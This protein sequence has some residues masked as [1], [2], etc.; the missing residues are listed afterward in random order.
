MNLN[1]AT[2]SSNSFNFLSSLLTEN[3]S[4][5]D[6]GEILFIKM[7]HFTDVEKSVFSNETG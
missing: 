3:D 6:F 5:Y 1:A 4:Y 7:G 2:F